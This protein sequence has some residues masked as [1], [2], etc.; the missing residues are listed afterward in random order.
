MPNDPPP[1]EMDV[2]NSFE[3]PFHQE[4]E[5]IE[6]NSITKSLIMK[7]KNM[8]MS[9]SILSCNQEEGIT[10]GSKFSN[11]REDKG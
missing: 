3:A 5:N 2:K 9:M 10:F 8:S 1:E 11:K 7:R 6:E 4:K